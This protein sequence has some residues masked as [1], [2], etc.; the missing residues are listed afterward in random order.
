MLNT[1]LRLFCNKCQK[2]TLN[3]LEHNVF[4]KTVL[5]TYYTSKLSFSQ[6]QAVLQHSY[7]DGSADFC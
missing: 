6:N 5:N 3:I 1:V 7:L 4:S 2:K